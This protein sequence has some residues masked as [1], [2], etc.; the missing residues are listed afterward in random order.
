MRGKDCTPLW[1]KGDPET[2][3]PSPLG[4]K[5]DIITFSKMAAPS[6]F[7]ARSV[8]LT[9]KVSSLQ[10]SVSAPPRYPRHLSA[11][12]LL[13]AIRLRYSYACDD[14]NIYRNVRTGL[15]DLAQDGERQSVA[16]FRRNL[17][18]ITATLRAVNGS[19]RLFWISSTPVPNVP[20]GPPVG[21]RPPLSAP[22]SH[23]HKVARLPNGGS[24]CRLNRTAARYTAWL[25]ADH[26]CCSGIRAMFRCT[27][28]RPPI[29]WRSLTCQPSTST[30]SS[31]STAGATRTT[32][33]AL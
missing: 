10:T 32:R 31:S 29:S 25:A 5:W 6:R 16:Q 27:T 22:R 20:L 9:W 26:R 15:H 28:R 17:A 3:S 11:I 1:L 14:I 24:V 13:S 30:A 23:T 4:R 7:V 21:R 18:N 2:P 33:P 8:S 12:H 19:P